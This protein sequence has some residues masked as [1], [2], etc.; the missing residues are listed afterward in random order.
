MALAVR[1]VYIHMYVFYAFVR[2]ICH[3]ALTQIN[4]EKSLIFRS[5]TVMRT[6]IPTEKKANEAEIHEHIFSVRR[7]AVGF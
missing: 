3:G 2:M 7:L 1:L 6:K 4:R 5:V